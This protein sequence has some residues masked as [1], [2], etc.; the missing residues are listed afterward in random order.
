MKHYYYVIDEVQRGP[1][2]F[3]ELKK[4]KISKQ[5]MVWYEGLTNWAEA[6]DL[7]ELVDLWITI[8][9][10]LKKKLPVYTT[11]RNTKAKSF[12]LD[13]RSKALVGGFLAIIVLVIFF[14]FSNR[15]TTVLH[16][17]TRAN[18]QMLNEQ[19]R[20]IDEQNQKIAEQERI[21]RERLD[22]KQREERQKVINELVFNLK[23]ARKYR[24]ESI[25]HLNDVSAFKLLRSSG[26]RNR[27]I[28]KAS[29]IVAKWEIK[30]NE[31]ENTLSEM[32]VAY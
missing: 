29:Q 16:Q 4:I 12:V 10:P 25:R 1:V 23:S 30:I 24:E 9:P 2:S 31:I 11:T 7:E 15:E 8:P 32:G 26:E 13:N 5:T 14:S 3:N 18:T 20:I 19:Q 28:N 17:Q 27:Q 6:G 21:E 22:Q